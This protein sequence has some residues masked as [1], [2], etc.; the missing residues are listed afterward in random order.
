MH[1][2]ELIIFPLPR[3]SSENV[4]G[5]KRASSLGFAPHC[6]PSSVTFIFGLVVA[7]VLA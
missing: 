1:F 4:F 6:A 3:A 7:S 5:G 2:V